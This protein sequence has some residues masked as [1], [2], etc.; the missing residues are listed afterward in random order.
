M[1]NRFK[2]KTVILIHL[3]LKIKAKIADTFHLILEHAVKRH[4]NESH[5]EGKQHP[6]HTPCS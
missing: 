6:L 1:N 4:F 3:W 5:V 2:V